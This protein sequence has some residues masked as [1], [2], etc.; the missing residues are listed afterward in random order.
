MRS[1]SSTPPTLPSID[2]QQHKHKKGW[3]DWQCQQSS[4]TKATTNHP[5]D[6]ERGAKFGGDGGLICPTRRQP[7]Q[8]TDQAPRH[9]TG[10]RHRPITSPRQ[11]QDL[12]HDPSTLPLFHFFHTTALDARQTMRYDA[13]TW[14]PSD[15]R[16]EGGF[17]V[18]YSSLF[19][20]FF[21][22]AVMGFFVGPFL[23][24]PV[25]QVSF[26]IRIFHGGTGNFH[27][28]SPPSRPSRLVSVS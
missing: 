6:R 27:L 2:T 25:S 18:F 26:Q 12:K 7:N 16:G 20:S 14:P 10:L 4:A 19:P 3:H 23:L 15:R 13:K 24:H 17:H 22:D 8:R 11:G 1:M 5:L 21:F 28:Q 9:L